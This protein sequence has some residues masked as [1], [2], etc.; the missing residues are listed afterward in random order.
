V[1]PCCAE[2]GPNRIDPHIQRPVTDEL[3]VNVE[4]RVGSWSARLSGVARRGRHMIASVNTLAPTG[5][6]VKYIADAGEDFLNPSDDRLL[7]VY[8]RDPISFGQDR[9]IL[10]NPAGDDTHYH[11]IEL[12]VERSTASRWRTRFDGTAYRSDAVGANRGF[13]AF[14]NDQ[15]I[16]GEVFENPNAGTYAR[17]HGFFD[18]GYVAKWWNSYRAPQDYVVSGVVRYQDGQA[19]TRMVVVPDLNQGAEAIQAYRRGRTRF[20][21]TLTVDAHVEK[22]FQVGRAHVAGIVEVFN[23][24]NTSAEVEEDVLTTPAFRRP[25]AVQPPRAVRFAL[26][27]GF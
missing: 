4:G 7:P 18:R 11:G 13:G 23:L 24:L 9:Y 19:F 6:T 21:F 17:G 3:L 14:E 8:D 20:T 15:G 16:V 12:T 10:T 27:L 25:T 5:Y 26:R 1:G 22:H 2:G